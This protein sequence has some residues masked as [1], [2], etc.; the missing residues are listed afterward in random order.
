M[1]DMEVPHEGPSEIKGNETQSQYPS[2]CSILDIASSKKLKFEQ[3]VTNIGGVID[4]VTPDNDTRV[5]NLK[6][7]CAYR[8]IDLYPSAKNGMMIQCESNIERKFVHLLEFHPG[9]IAFKEQPC[10]IKWVDRDGYDHS[11]IPDFR[12]EFRNGNIL[13]VEI[14]P[15]KALND[16]D[17]KN[18]TEILSYG[19]SK[20]FGYQ[21][22]VIM[23]SQLDQIALLNA[24]KI[25]RFPNEKIPSFEYEVAR[26]IFEKSLTPLSMDGIQ[27]MQ[28]MPVLKR[29]SHTV[30][31]LIRRGDVIFDMSQPFNEKTILK[32][33]ESLVK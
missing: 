32:W 30:K 10:I 28:V 16:S 13:I 27:S 20:K 2:V 33:N 23:E 17:L 4:L 15:D 22:L 3:T 25:R 9:V 26:R 31:I 29:F 12:I 5:R 8:I 7:N 6:K 14:K 19:L 11:H 24:D 21:Y 18:R 1:S